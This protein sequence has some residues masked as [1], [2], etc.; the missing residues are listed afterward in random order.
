MATDLHASSK[1]SSSNKTKRAKNDP[2]S[3]IMSSQNPVLDAILDELKGLKPFMV[4][5]TAKLQQ[6][7]DRWLSMESKMLEM[8]HRVSS[9]QDVVVKIPL[10]EQE[11]SKLKSHTEDL[12]N[13]NRRN[14]LRLYG[15]PE[16]L[17]GENLLTFLKK[18]LPDLLDLPESPSLNIQRAHRLGRIQQQSTKPRGIIMLFLEFTDLLRVLNAAREKRHLVW[19]GQRLFISQDL[20]NATNARRKEFLAL[21]PQMRQMNIRYGILHPCV[22]KITFEGSTRS[23][24]DP[25]Q[26]KSFLHSISTRHMDANIP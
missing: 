5:T 9:L 4:S 20:S 26:L 6:I 13:R 24:E 21:R 10:M 23:Y 25:A 1:T 12:E 11:I 14:N 15:L 16:A 19:S 2:P 7:E 18:F 22:C 8:E 17:E 3:P